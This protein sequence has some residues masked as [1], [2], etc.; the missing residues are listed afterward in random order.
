MKVK[1]LN[2][3]YVTDKILDLIFFNELNSHTF[4]FSFL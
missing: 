1:G 2:K 3:K 4:I